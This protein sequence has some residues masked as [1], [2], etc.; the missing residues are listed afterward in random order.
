MS[1]ANEPPGH[2]L[3]VA[4]ESV[5]ELRVYH[6]NPRKGD[7]TAIRES[8][9]V[10]GQYRP[11]VANRGTHTKRPNEVLAGNHTLMAAR[12]EGWSTVA[13]AWVDVDDDQCARIVAA[14]NRTA[15]LG[16]YDEAL[17]VELLQEL[18]DL[19]GTG[20]DPGDL[21]AMEAL[22][23]ESSATDSDQ[24]ILDDTDR[25]AWPLIRVQVPHD[26]YQRW[27]CIEGE[28][29]LQRIKLVLDLAGI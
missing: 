12:D 13:V 14:D 21:Q 1:A 25:A 19:A 23:Q 11:I 27:Q 28:D 22:L 9:R 24:D 18:P 8:L 3:K 2:E 7:V 17:L 16:S 20:F 15:D 6:R 10:N 5:S 26:V 29:D 4:S